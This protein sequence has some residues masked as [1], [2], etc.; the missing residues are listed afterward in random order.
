MRH[1]KPVE[2]L[3][4]VGVVASDGVGSVSHGQPVAQRRRGR[5]RVSDAASARLVVLM[6]VSVERHR[7]PLRSDGLDGQDS[8]PLLGQLGA[9]LRVRV[10]QREVGHDDRDRKRYRQDA[11]QRAQRPDEHADVG[12]GRHVAVTDGRHRDDGPPQSDRDRREVVGRVVLDALG[13]VDQRREDDDA[14]DEEEDEQHQLVSAGFERVNEDL[15][16]WRMPRQLRQRKYTI[17]LF[18]YMVS[19]GSRSTIYPYEELIH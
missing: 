5:R 10:E 19:A 18:L 4:L 17:T 8:P 14:D 11:G 12:L 15:E 7:R 16:P 6:V 2:F 3:R 13:V 1:T 9:R